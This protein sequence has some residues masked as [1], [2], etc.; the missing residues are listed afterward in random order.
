[1]RRLNGWVR[2]YI[3][4]LVPIALSSWIWSYSAE[5][6]NYEGF[7][8]IRSNALEPQMKNPECIKILM[9]NPVAI[10][11]YLTQNNLSR[12]TTFNC[13]MII[14]F[15]SQ[16]REYQNKH[17]LSGKIIDR[18]TIEATFKEDYDAQKLRATTFGTGLCIIIY[19]ILFLMAWG[20][21]AS[22]RWVIQGF[23]KNN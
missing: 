9:A 15:W 14:D 7:S 22:I 8:S 16:I 17:N 19:T 20:S 23:K 12:E 21:I 10:D 2:L 11:G 6:K 18:E 5:N 1:M 4:L 13:H 3:V